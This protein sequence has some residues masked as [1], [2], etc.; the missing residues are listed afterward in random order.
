MVFG[1]EIIVETA[2]HTEDVFGFFAIKDIEDAIQTILNI[3]LLQF[4][5]RIKEFSVGT[6][7]VFQTFYGYDVA[8]EKKEVDDHQA[9]LGATILLL[10]ILLIVVTANAIIDIPVY[11]I[12][13]NALTVILF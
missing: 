8:F 11:A 13:P 6:R 5:K 1:V 2:Q 12:N 7:V 3:H 4:P 9:L 10:V